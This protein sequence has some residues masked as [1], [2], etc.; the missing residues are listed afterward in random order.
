MWCELVVMGINIFAPPLDCVLFYYLQKKDL[1]IKSITK[2][3]LAVQARRRRKAAAAAAQGSADN[4][5]TQSAVSEA[6]RTAGWAIAAE[7]SPPRQVP[8]SSASHRPAA[9]DAPFEEDT[10]QPDEV[11]RAKEAFLLHGKDFIAVAQFVTT[12]TIMQCRRLYM[13]YKQRRGMD[14]T[15]AESTD[16]PKST[17]G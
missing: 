5:V 11:V 7:D 1:K 8:T 15:D 2:Q 16:L 17:R 6:P 14:L 12:R 3:A 13:E 4:N 10:W 9:H